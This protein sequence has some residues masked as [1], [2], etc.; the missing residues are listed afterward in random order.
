M[1]ILGFLSFLLRRARTLRL[2]LAAGAILCAPQAFAQGASCA[3]LQAEIARAGRAPAGDSRAAAR[4]QAELG[5]ALASARALRC[6]REQFLFFGD[7]PPPQCAGLNARIAQLRAAI[8]ALRGG[9]DARRQALIA[10]FNAECRGRPVYAPQRSRSFLDELFGIPPEESP[11]M[12]GPPVEE[13][14]PDRDE[15]ESGDNHPRGGSMAVCVRSCDGGF[16]PLNFSAAR[17]NL[18]DLAGLCHALCPNAE[19]TLYTKPPH[20]DISSAISINGETYSDHPNALKFQTS[21]DA[22]CGCKPPGKSWVEALEEAE[23]ILAETYK[24]DAVVSAEQAEKLSRPVAAGEGGRGAQKTAG[25]LRPKEPAPVVD[26]KTPDVYRE[27]VGPDGVKKRVR[28]V[29]PSL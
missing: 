29:A 3:A 13:P 5:R 4:Q 27:V 23:R 15:I 11:A 10:R 2:L 8:G 12:R 18:D 6:D 16:F 28:V 14:L 1:H 22:S 20:S 19:V 25:G 21:Y 26:A 7:P 24:K 17:A 9:D